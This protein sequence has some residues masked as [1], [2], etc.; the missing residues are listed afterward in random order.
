MSEAAFL[1]MMD[2][3]IKI[4]TRTGHSNYGEPTY[5]SSTSSYR[6]RVVEKPGYVHTPGGEDV[7][8]SHVIWAASTGAVSI[9]VSDRLTVGGVVRPMVAVERYPDETGPHHVKILC[10]Y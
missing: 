4:S 10:G 2:S 3:T 1:S 9:T 5:A 8:Y 7:A 6:A